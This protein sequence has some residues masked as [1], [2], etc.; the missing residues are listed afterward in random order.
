MLL[1]PKAPAPRMSLWIAIRLRSRQTIWR[2]GSNP[3]SLR[4]IHEERELILTTE[5]W[6]SV[7]LTASTTPLSKFPFFRIT[8]ASAPLGGP[9]S[10]V[11][12]KPPLSSIFSMFDLVFIA[13]PQNF[14][15]DMGNPKHEIRNSKQ[16]RMTKARNSK[17]NHVLRFE[18]SN[19]GFVSDFD[20][21][22]SYLLF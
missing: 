16:F 8:S 10:E 20:I 21:R 6:L 2:I 12:T 15:P 11:T 18:N 7:T 9:H 17:L 19:F 22:I 1:I 14:Q 4:M 13:T 5:V 3:I